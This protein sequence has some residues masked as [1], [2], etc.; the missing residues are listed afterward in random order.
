MYDYFFDVDQLQVIS[1]PPVTD[2]IYTESPGDG[3][4]VSMQML[5]PQTL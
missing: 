4:Y 5:S 2:S 3:N 1:I